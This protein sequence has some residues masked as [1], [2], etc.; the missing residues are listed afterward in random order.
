MKTVLQELIERIDFL[1]EL[2]EDTIEEG[3]NQTLIDELN[4]ELESL[5]DL[6]DDIE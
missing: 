1:E 6:L 4:M 5:N 3:D 2:L